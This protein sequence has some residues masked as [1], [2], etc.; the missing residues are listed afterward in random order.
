MS[1]LAVR[2]LI[3]DTLKSIDDSV[4]FA[5][6]RASDFNSLGKREDKRVQLDPLKQSLEFTNGSYNLSKTYQVGM[7]FY[8]LDSLQGDEETTAS[9]LDEMDVL[10]DKFI[11]KLNFI[12]NED[13]TTDISAQ[14]SELKSFKKESAIKV[15]ADCLSGWIVSF[16]ITV[17]DSFDYCSLYDN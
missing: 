1:H 10:S 17:P 5:Y 9:I 7:V 4:L 15:T 11:N 8:R 16:S 2:T 13:T 6:S 3:S 14:H 12:F